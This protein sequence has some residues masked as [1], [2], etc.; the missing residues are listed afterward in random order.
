MTYGGKTWKISDYVSWVQYYINGKITFMIENKR[1]KPTSKVKLLSITID[2]KLLFTT[3]IEDLRSTAS[4]RLQ[5][6]ARIHTFIPFGEAK[7]LSKTY[8]MSIKF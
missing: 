7:R 1:V 5:A 8:I 2:D 3:H 6:L 4:N